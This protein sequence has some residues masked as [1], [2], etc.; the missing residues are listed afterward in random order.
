MAGLNARRRP[1]GR[2]SRRVIGVSWFKVPKA[3]GF[4]KGTTDVRSNMVPRGDRR[5]SG[6][7]LPLLRPTTLSEPKAARERDP[8]Q[9]RKT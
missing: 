7:V 5:M 3:T 8:G 4:R 6:R 9:E 1:V 2:V